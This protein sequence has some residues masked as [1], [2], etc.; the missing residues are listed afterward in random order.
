[1]DLAYSALALQVQCRSVN[2]LDI[3]AARQQIF[4]NIEHV[5]KQ[6]KSS[7][8]FIKTFSGEA[9]RLVVLPEYFLTGFP[10]GESIAEWKAKAVLDIDGE[11]Y[12]RLAKIAQDN[13][14]YL[15]GNAYEADPNFPELYFQTC[16]ILSPA[17]NTV[18]RYRRLISMFSPTPHDVWQPYLDIYGYEAVFPVAKTEIGNLAAIASEEILYPEIARCLAMR[19]A[20]VFLHNTSEIASPGLTPKDI[21]K[22]ARAIENMAYVVSANSAGIA[23]ISLPVN[24]ADGMSKIID[25]KGRVLAE[26]TIGET[27]VAYAELNISSL[28]A[29]RLK[30]AMTNLLARQRN[31]LF[32]PTYQ[33][34]VYPANNMLVQ[35][36]D[37]TPINRQHFIDTQ[38]NV[39]DDLMAK[40][41]FHSD[42]SRSEPRK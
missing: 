29:L 30:P 14:I 3:A 8:G 32:A 20:E 27:M 15:S 31:E 13:N 7:L 41:I 22:R 6:V 24:S 11:E 38:V 25:T 36:N 10:M 39:I 1:M 16:F 2:S 26:S 21:A 17:G 34:T 42:A 18:L 23:D 35:L 28:R 4:N 19:G 40:G 12:N 9:V 33:Q 5:A 37:Q